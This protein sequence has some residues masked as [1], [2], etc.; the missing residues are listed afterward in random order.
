M[1]LCKKRNE[2]K[3][4]L[5]KNKIETKIHYPVPLHKQKP[6]RNNSKKFLNLKNSENQAKNLLTLPVH[7]FLSKKQLDYMIKK[8]VPNKVLNATIEERNEMR[9]DDI[10]CE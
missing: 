6:Y 1:I 10:N 4:Y 7:Q 3:K 8:K 9:D 2:L 5:E